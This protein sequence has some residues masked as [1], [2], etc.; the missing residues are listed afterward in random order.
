MQR[1][2]TLGP[3]ERGLCG[4]SSMAGECK[5]SR[6]HATGLRRLVAPVASGHELPV[7]R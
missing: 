1:K 7:E 2:Q 3:A 6:Q 5:V 4:A